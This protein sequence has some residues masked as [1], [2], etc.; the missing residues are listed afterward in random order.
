[1]FAKLFCGP[2]FR[3]AGIIIVIT[4]LVRTGQAEAKLE[5]FREIQIKIVG[6]GQPVLMIPGFDSAADSWAETCAVMQQDKVQCR[7]VQ[8]P[9]FAGLPAAADADQNAWLD[10]M[11]DRLLAYIEAEKLKSPIV[12]GHSLGGV[13]ALQM[14]IKRPAAVGGLV[15]VDSLPFLGQIWLD[16]T[17][18]AQARQA[19]QGMRQGMLA[20]SQAEYESAV[21][22]SVKNMAHAPERVATLVT[23]SK[24]S[25]R[26]TS[27][28]ALYSLLST[29]LRSPLGEL[30]SPTLV[31]GSW[32]AYAPMG[33]TKTSTAEIFKSQY[34]ML[35]DVQIELSDSGYH[36][37]M[38][39]D[40]QWL[41]MQVR[42]FLRR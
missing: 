26:T 25:D 29:D 36:F 30:T 38:W 34:A 35:K 9:G 33:A 37:L 16:V 3:W 32:A 6:Q 42:S 11:R 40:P 31:I 7:I 22:A 10:D 18:V 21:T 15:I 19:A 28:A 24:A 39:D 27:A 41:Q 4:A 2:V 1:M 14:A 17:D 23:W 13:L 12:M 8:L 5:A 20:Q